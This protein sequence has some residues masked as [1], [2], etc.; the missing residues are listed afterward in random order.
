MSEFSEIKG[1]DPEFFIEKRN[2][3]IAGLKRRFSGLN[4]NSILVLRGADEPT[5]YDTDT[6]YYYFGQESCY[7]YLT[8]VR[9]PGTYA[10]LDIQNGQF[11]LFIKKEDD[12]AR[13]WQKV[14]TKEDV[15]AKYKVPTHYMDEL[16]PFIQKR[17]MEVIYIL[18]GTN[19][20]SGLPVFSAELNF[21]GELAY[22]NKRIVNDEHI[23]QVLCE[24]R[25][26]KTDKER[27]LLAYIGQITA[28]AHREMM[29][30]IKPGMNERE[31]EL[32]FLNYLRKKYDL[33]FFAYGP[34]AV[35]GTSNAVL[36]YVH[37]DKIMKDGDLFLSDQGIQMLGYD[38]DITTTFPIN[39]KFTKEQREIYQVVYDSNQAVEQQIKAGQITKKEVD[40]F[41]K[42][43]VL[44][45]LKKLGILTADAD[46]D[47][48]FN[49]G[50]ARIFYP[51][52]YGHYLGLDCH[53]VGPKIDYT[54]MQIIRNGMFITNE[55]GCYFNDMLL[56]QARNNPDLAPYINFE[57]IDKYK[58]VGGVRIEDNLMYFD[59]HVEN[60]THD[61][62]RTPD[63]IEKFMEE[64]N[65]YLLSKKKNK[66]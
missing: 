10:I 29:I 9:I 46:I 15:E 63:E 40:T 53:D 43:V 41:S 32:V 7:Y 13:I 61:L 1:L 21:V 44:Q 6:N 18:S 34:I 51:H 30:Q 62:P 45:G 66:H 52:G 5:K 58:Y 36:H 8:G 60:Y 28:D 16:Y 48:L 14:L 49:K 38:S 37:N 27:E 23:Y 64:N 20:N 33:R 22:L 12:N 26:I 56:E 17:N 54:S 31:M 50:M 4:T 25:M 35:T 39:G 55:P 59:D 42:K 19:G 3:L 24:N 57:L 2:N 11:D 65:L 47:D